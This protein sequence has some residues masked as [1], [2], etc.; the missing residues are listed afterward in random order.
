MGNGILTVSEVAK[1]KGTT[2]QAVYAA[3]ESGA[4]KA[5]IAKVE[6]T[7]ITEAAMN[8]W[9]PSPRSIRNAGRPRKQSRRYC[10]KCEAS[11][12]ETDVEAGYCTNCS[13]VL[14]N[15]KA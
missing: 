14:P 15:K 6:V 5:T 13:A 8:K 9:K 11:I 4:L 12:T 7:G 1:R 10:P 2:R 3:I